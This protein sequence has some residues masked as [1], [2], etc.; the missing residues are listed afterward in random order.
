LKILLENNMENNYKPGDF[1]KLIGQE[2]AAEV[3]AVKGKDLEIAIGGMK[4]NVKIN[5]VTL[6][7]PPA[8][9]VNYAQ[10][11]APVMDTREKLLH[12]KFELDLRGK[13]KDEVFIELTP[14]ID[15]AILLGIKEALIM[16]GRG[17]G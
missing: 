10:F 2:T 15:D 8:V 5:K 12:F 9:K 16:H 4:M 7:A 14:W 13:T 11:Q 1:V 6:A 17:T 3:I